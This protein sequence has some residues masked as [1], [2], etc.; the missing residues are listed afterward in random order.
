MTDVFGRISAALADY[1]TIEQECHSKV[2][3]MSIPIVVLSAV[4]LILAAPA[5]SQV[6]HVVEV[7]MPIAPSPVPAEGQ[8]HLVYEL[9]VTNLSWNAATL[10][11]VQALETDGAVLLLTL[12][13]EELAGDIRIVG[14]PGRGVPPN[15]GGVVL[16]AGSRAIVYMWLAL[17]SD[18]EPTSIAHRMSLFQ[19]SPEGDTTR[20]EFDID[21][22][23]LGPEPVVISAP[24]RGGS[25][26]VTTF[27]RRQNDTGHRRASLIAVSGRAALA[28]R[29]A[30]DW[31]RIVDGS[32]WVVGG[33][34]N[35]DTHIWGQEVL[36][37][38]DGV[39][40]E[41][42]DGIPENAP[43]SG[44]VP[45]T[46]ETL[47]GN[48][49]VLDIGNDRYAVYAHL[50]PGSL[51]VAVGDRVR[52]GD[53][54]GLVGNSGSSGGPHLHF[55]IT[56]APSPMGGEGVPYMIDSFEVTGRLTSLRVS[57]ETW[58]PE[59]RE[60]EMP[61]EGAIVTFSSKSR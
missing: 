10:T 8:I 25:W 38:A 42:K 31:G 49:I 9:H 45:I 4:L 51:R 28:Q 37:V 7:Q 59:H 27:G 35:S 58:A 13:G 36:A 15:D 19:V 32:P 55:H 43:G 21:P 17:E 26:W 50:Q 40:L 61:M 34:Q 46:L 16:R 54:V 39:V 11:R 2:I 12:E 52:V 20:H 60:R 14:A 22:L 5:T 24:F 18:M 56:D 48:Y 53:D 30:R 29:F 33:E 1:H 23:M 6:G 44:A 47:L 41:A 3:T 57:P